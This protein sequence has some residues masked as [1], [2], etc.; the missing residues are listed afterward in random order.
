[1]NCKHVKQKIDFF[2]LGKKGF[3][4]K[5]ASL[6]ISECP[7]CREYYE[8]T[9]QASKLIDKL[10]NT[11]PASIDTSELTE[12]IMLGINQ[13][14]QEK[15]SPISVSFFTSSNLQRLLAAA[16]ICLLL[17]FGYEQ[18]RVLAKLTRLENENQAIG[19]SPQFE[20]AGLENTVEGLLLFKIKIQ[21]KNSGKLFKS[22]GLENFDNQK[23]LAVLNQAKQGNFSSKELNQLLGS[24]ISADEANILISKIKSYDI[25]SLTLNNLIKN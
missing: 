17:I 10:R 25:E 16:S 20:N 19:L 11:E 1:M 23:I 5:K 18:Y 21:N 7:S 13:A 9:L 22:L 2:L 6:H 14:V 4:T 15:S 12:K 8:S 24:S 3:L